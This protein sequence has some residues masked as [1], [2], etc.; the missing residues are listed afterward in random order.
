MSKINQNK[1]IVK[2]F[3]CNTCKDKSFCNWDFNRFHFTFPNGNHISVVWG[4]GSYSDNHDADLLFQ[5]KGIEDIKKVWQSFFNSNTC[6][7]VFDC[8]KRTAKRVAKHFKTD[9]NPLGYLVMKDFVWLFNELSKF[10]L[11]KPHK[12]QKKKK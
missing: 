8:E 9:E 11:P 7:V 10:H 5:G 3:R 4:Y 2:G 6:E 12:G 1:R